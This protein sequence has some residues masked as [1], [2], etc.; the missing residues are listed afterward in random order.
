MTAARCWIASAALAFLPAGAAAH[1]GPP[2]PVLED[3]LAGRYRV[4]VWTDPDATDDGSAGGQFWVI[5][6]GA[7]GG[8]AP[9]GLRIEV[10]VRARRGGGVSRALAA[11][12]A[13][14][15]GHWFAAVVMDHEGLFDVGVDLAGSLGSVRVESE[16]E[17][18]YDLRP[19]P[20]TLVLYLLPFLAAA[21]LWL[22]AVLGRRRYGPAPRAGGPG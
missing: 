18:T 19:P 11:P 22:K 12:A 15:E 6:H 4:S 8:A 7:D 13:G 17:A 16:V 20:A 2:F 14:G 3:H 21:G 9:P 5:V 1:D 10:A